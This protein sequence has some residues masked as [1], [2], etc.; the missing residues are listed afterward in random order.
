MTTLKEFA[1]LFL[2]A[3]PALAVEPHVEIKGPS[4]ATAGV[5]CYLDISGTITEKPL[6]VRS[7]GP[8]VLT[9]RIWYDDQR[10]PGLVEMTAPSAGDYWIFVVATA[11]INGENEQDFAPWKVT[12]GGTGPRP[13][14]PTPP[15]PPGPTPVAGKLWGLL[16]LPTYH[17]APEAALRTSRVIRQAF[18]DNKVYFASYLLTESEIQTPERLA[19]IRSVDGPPCVLWIGE[20]GKIIKVTTITS[21]ASVVADVR[22]IRGGK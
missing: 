4:T 13:P 2:L 8:G 1:I 18:A 21:E 5:A 12:V 3:A 15:I 6:K 9:I 11:K 17:T 19:A 14:P 16:V 22:A 10:Q 20:N 7:Q